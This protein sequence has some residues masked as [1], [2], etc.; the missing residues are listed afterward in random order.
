VSDFSPNGTDTFTVQH[1]EDAPVIE[2]EDDG[3]GLFDVPEFTAALPRKRHSS[4]INK[5]VTLEDLNGWERHRLWNRGSAFARFPPRYGQQTRAADAEG[6][7][8]DPF[9]RSRPP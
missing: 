8:T 2:A 9:R 7:G 5:R 3:D 4:L 1:L 6:F